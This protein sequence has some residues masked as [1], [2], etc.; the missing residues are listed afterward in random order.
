MNYLVV[1][2]GTIVFATLG[3]APANL[4]FDS[5]NGSLNSRFDSNLRL[6]TQDGVELSLNSL[7]ETPAII[8]FGFTNCS[9]VCPNTLS[10]VDGW[11]KQVDPTGTLLRA[12]FITVDPKRDTPEVMKKF[13]S[14]FSNRIIGL[15]GDPVNVMKFAKNFRIYVKNVL[16]D[17][18]SDSE[19]K[20]LVDHTTALLLLNSSGSIM[21]MIQY[22]EDSSSA[23][24]KISRLIAE[25]KIVQ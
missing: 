14:R 25:D 5:K 4:A 23:I 11:L 20:Y 9:I 19:K 18:K 8:F 7:Y 3:G 21:G 13:V 22:N 10:A 12:Y 15:S 1:I 17:D 2:L 16:A 6:V 24:K